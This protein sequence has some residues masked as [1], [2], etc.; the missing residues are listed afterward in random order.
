MFALQHCSPQC[1]VNDLDNNRVYGL[2]HHMGRGEHDDFE[3]YLSNMRQWAAE[4]QNGN[5]SAGKYFAI[6]PSGR[7]ETKLTH[8][9]LGPLQ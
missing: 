7:G 3:S 2:F 1:L 6:A 8:K 4:C 5:L 9:R